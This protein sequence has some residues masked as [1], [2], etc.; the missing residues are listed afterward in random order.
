MPEQDM[1]NEKSNPMSIGEQLVNM[2]QASEEPSKD[3]V[4]EVVSYKEEYYDV[5]R[6]KDE[7]GSFIKE[8]RVELDLL[9]NM[10]AN[11]EAL[12]KS[13]FAGSTDSDEERYPHAAEMFKVYKSAIIE[14]S[15]S[16]YSA[17]LEISGRDAYSTLKVPE[18]KDT[19][20]NQFK[21]MSLLEKL[22]G[23]TVDDWLLKGEAV[24]FIKLKKTKEEYRSKSTLVDAETGKDVATFKVKEFVSYKDID[25]ERIDP[26]D[27][28]VD[29]FDYRNDPRGATKIVRT[30]ISPKELLTSNMYPM[31]SQEDKDNIIAS[32]GRNGSGYNFQYS[33]MMSS[34]DQLRNKTDVNK[35]EVLTFYGDYIT[36]DNKVLRNIKAILVGGRIADAK[37]SAVNTNRIIYA[38]YKIDDNTHRSIAPLASTEVVNR[39]INRVADMFVKNLDDASNPIVLYPKG[40][41]N[42]SQ[43]KEI[44]TKRQ[45][46]YNDVAQPPTFYAPPVA[47]TQ[48]LQ[49]INMILD[50]NKNVL[51]LNNYLAG[52]TDGAVRTARESSILFQKA[53]A[54]MRVETD[55]FS[56]NFM[57][58]LFVSFY[59]FNRELALSLGDPLDEIYTDPQLKVSISTNASR[60][61]KEGELQRLMQMLQLPIAQMI[62]SNLQPDQIVLAVRYLMAKAELTDADNLLE[63]IDSQT[64][65]PNISGFTDDEGNPVDESN[66]SNVNL[67]QQE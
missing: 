17:L 22:S 10:Q 34:T 59:A 36:S 50:Q 7:I 37:Y 43:V 25:I 21:R 29:A 42:A 48:G 8:K 61:D 54:R 41:L 16:G 12:K 62:F 40:S 35:I 56:Y 6:Y 49:L 60:S 44:R 57:L 1:N 67:P 51:G 66:N 52:N 64:G 38:S 31:L 4:D 46:E 39:L 26:L 20:T 5:S 53:N 30:W 27:F 19:M 9:S 65:E 33:A 23:D 11:Y 32:V 13:I 47:A 24:S 45:C 18:L 58:A 28:Y 63:L 55:V 15:L 3:A 14:S 2:A